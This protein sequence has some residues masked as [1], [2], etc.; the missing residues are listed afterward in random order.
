MPDTQVLLDSPTRDASL[1][2]APFACSWTASGED[3][4]WVHL[5]GELDIA[6]SP[7]LARTLSEAQ[8]Q[9]RLVVAD[10]RQVAF[11]DSSVLHVLIDAT[12]RA[13]H[14]G[15]RLVVLRGPPHVDRVFAL[16]GFDDVAEVVDLDAGSPPVLALLRLA[17]E[18]R[19]SGP[20]ERAIAC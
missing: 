10:L 11:A 6:T 7:Q 12:T 9:A 19:D 14:E 16:T 20:A 1:L 15:S 4:A 18:E 17:A 13:Q 8:G 5:T 2:P 3:A